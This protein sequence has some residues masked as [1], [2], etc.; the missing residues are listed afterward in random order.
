[1]AIV[2]P[3]IVPP[4]HG[5]IAIRPYGEHILKLY[6]SFAEIFVVFTLSW[7][8]ICKIFQ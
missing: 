2:P 7:Y 4:N 6:H 8:I 3:T 5:R 1:M